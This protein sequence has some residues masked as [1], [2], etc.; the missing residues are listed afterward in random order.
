MTVSV[1]AQESSPAAQPAEEASTSSKPEKKS[2]PATEQEKKD[3]PAAETKAVPEPIKLEGVFT[4]TEIQELL[5]D[6][7][8]IKTFTVDRT[9]SHGT[10]VTQGQTVIWFDADELH[11]SHETAVRDRQLAEIAMEELHLN[12]EQ[13]GRMRELER[14]AAER[15]FRDARQEFENFMHVDKERQIATAEFSLESSQASLE[16][17]TEELEQLEQMYKEDELTEESE[18]IVLKR[19]RRSVEAAQFSLESAEIRTARTLEQTIPRE[20]EAQKTNIMKAELTHTKA[21][22]TLELAAQKQQMEFEKE[23]RKLETQIQDLET[24]IQETER[25][26]LKA[27]VDGIFYFGKLNNGKLGDKPAEINP[28]DSVTSQQ[29]VATIVNDEKLIVSLEVPEKHFRQIRE[30]D[31]AQVTAASHPDHAITA[32]VLSISQVP[33]SNGKFACELRIRDMGAVHVV[34]GMTCNVEFSVRD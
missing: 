9:L 34:P 19:A 18:E 1:A 17:A 21:M 3:A 30:G 23:Q 14:E 33:V 16:Y 13:A 6:T 2:E 5:A 20:E 4:S 24:T 12:H 32:V 27:Q 8:Q 25:P 29:V 22:R 7:E 10:R 28:G 31:V 11:E 26:E 15:T